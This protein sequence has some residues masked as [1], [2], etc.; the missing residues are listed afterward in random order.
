MYIFFYSKIR[1]FQFAEIKFNSAKL[2][3]RAFPDSFE[4][5]KRPV[6]GL[7]LLAEVAASSRTLELSNNF[8]V[9]K[10]L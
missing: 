10:I 4:V 5:F 3:L 8:V 9:L 7:I 6:R 1:A 2:S